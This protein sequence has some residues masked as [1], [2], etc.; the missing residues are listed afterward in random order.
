VDE[1]LEATSGKN[2]DKAQ[3]KLLEETIKPYMS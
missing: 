2:A 1:K 3:H